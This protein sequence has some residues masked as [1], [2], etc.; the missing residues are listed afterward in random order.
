METDLS[1]NEYAL[2][3]Q[4]LQSDSQDIISTTSVI[5]GQGLSLTLLPAL[6]TLSSYWA[7]SSSLK[8]RGC[9]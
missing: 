6:G 3:V 1:G 8:R 2:C 7:A 5:R 4:G 9:A